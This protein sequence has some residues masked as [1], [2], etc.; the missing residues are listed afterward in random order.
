MRIKANKH[1]IFC[2][3][4]G[5]EKAATVCLSHSLACSGV[6]WEPQ[7]P[8]LSQRFRVL[9]YDTRGHGG[10]D[11]PSPPYSLDQLADDAV[12]MLDE[13]GI[14]R[15]HWLGLSM[16]GMIGQNLALRYPQ[17]LLSLILCDT[18]SV[19]SDAAQPIWED[20]IETANRDGMAPLCEPTLARW[21]TPSYLEKNPPSLAS[22]RAQI[23]NTPVRG[24]IGC[25]EAVRRIDYINRLSGIR[26]PTR[27][28]V[29]ADDPATTPDD[30]KAIHE[31]IEGSSLVIIDDAAHLSN[32]EQ[33]EAFDQAVLDFLESR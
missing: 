21:F 30:A 23:L 28:I 5:S 29:G 7:M 27:V 9:R 24:Y 17:R 8:A 25:C 22:I 15:V 2:Q 11:A 31:R 4:A 14:E 18:L 3:I 10:S 32:V 1:F 12:A 20:R 16:G 19:I 13:L 33:P 26:L 6:M